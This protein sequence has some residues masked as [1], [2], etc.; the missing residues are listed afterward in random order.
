VS[1]ALARFAARRAVLALILVWLA[2]SAAFLLT[3]RAPGDHFESLG[4][5]PR[6]VAAAR[7]AFGLDRPW[8]VQYADWLT[9]AVR[10]DFGQSMSFRRP[11]RQL[12]AERIGNTVL[13]GVCAL[14]LATAIGLPL[15]TLTGSRRGGLLLAAARGLSVLLLSLHPLIVAFVLLFAAAATGWL[16]IGGTPLGGLETASIAA[17]A[18]YL[19]LPTLALTLPLAAV[20]ERL[21]AGAIRTALSAPSLLAARARG[22]PDHL[23]LWRHAFALAMPSVLAVYGLLVGSV[24]SG[25]FVVEIVMSWP[26]LGALMYEGLLSRDLY[27]V[28]GCAA[29][30]AALLAVGVFA[31]DVTAAAIDPRLERTV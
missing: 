14:A 19:V 1:P 10:L 8:A 4:A 13:I 16:P 7:H 11:V 21:Q 23:V 3:L 5:N 30:A 26:G 31:A 27:L 12:L 28:V 6:E 22:V 9:R 17:R 29:A 2:A 15:G 18:R 20:I 25:S 24:L